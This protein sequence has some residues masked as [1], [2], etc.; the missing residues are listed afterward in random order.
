M[1][2]K[3]KKWLGIEGVKVEL[4]APEAVL[5]SDGVIEGKIRFHT[6]HTQKVYS[7]RIKLVERYS[8]GRGENKLVDEYELASTEL[9]QDIEVP[10]DDII[11]IDFKLPFQLVKSDIEAL[12]TKNLLLKGISRLAQWS[13]NAH[14]TFRLEAEAK[15]R[16]TALS[17]FA[18]KNILI[19]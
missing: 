5:E 11:E 3:V 4:I 1:F 14:S 10:Q 6:M 16:G 17:P 8:R 19:K 2:G 7:V 13:R 9:V 12:G 15:V 18:Q